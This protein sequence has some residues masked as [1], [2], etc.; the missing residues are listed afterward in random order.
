MASVNSLIFFLQL[1]QGKVGIDYPALVVVSLAGET[2]SI[3]VLFGC[4]LSS[5]D[6]III[7][8]LFVPG[9]SI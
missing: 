9:S 7:N 6:K 4:R 3:F 2:V 5:D 1:Y 8:F